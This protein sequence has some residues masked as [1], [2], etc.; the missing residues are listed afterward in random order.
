MRLKLSTMGISVC[1]ILGCSSESKQV[2]VDQ[3]YLGTTSVQVI[4]Q[5]GKQF[6]DLNKNGEL[7]PYEDWRL[8]PEERSLD[9]LSRMSLEEKV[10]MM[11]IADMRMTNEIS[12]MDFNARQT[13]PITTAFNEEDVIVANNQF[14]GEP[15]PYPV[16]NTVGTTKGIVERKLR[17]FIWRTT[18]AP[19][20]TM[21]KWAN[22]VQALAESDNLGIPV[23]FA[24]NPRNHITGGSLGATGSTSVGFSKWPSEIGLAAMQDPNLIRKFGDMARQEWVSVG[25]RKGYMYM[26]DLATEPPWQRIEGTFGEDPTL[27]HR[28]SK[29]LSWDFKATA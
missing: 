7:D 6:K 11:L 28:A 13:A 15:L 22:K 3:P 18:S 4:E 10:G 5:D 25:I 27:A 16:M 1:V 8:S 17:H 20:D 2:G 24:S 9:L 12:I 19:A 29:L 21:A 14:T 26:A 23:L